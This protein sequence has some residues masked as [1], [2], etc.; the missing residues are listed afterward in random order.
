MKEKVF[1]KS[2]KDVMEYI[3]SLE[4]EARKKD[5]K[6]L[7]DIFDRITGLKPDLWA[8]SMVGY[9]DYHYVNKTNE[10]EAFIIGFAPRKANM[11][12]YVAIQGYKKYDEILSRLGKYKLGKVCLYITNLKR[13]DMDVL[14]E[15]L[16]EAYKDAINETNTTNGC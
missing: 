5:S 3:D 13:V 16:E 8:G 9:G 1:V 4:N 15:L 11:V 6:T 2:D 10:G 12:I 14:V 7:L